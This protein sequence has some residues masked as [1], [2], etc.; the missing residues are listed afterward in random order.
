MSSTAKKT[1]ISS[2]LKVEKKRS[3]GKFVWGDEILHADNFI[4][5]LAAS[6]CGTITFPVS[7]QVNY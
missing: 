6:Q 4:T 7:R 1:A 5:S 3:S 2:A